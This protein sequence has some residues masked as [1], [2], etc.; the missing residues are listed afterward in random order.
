MHAD[1]SPNFLKILAM[2]PQLTGSELKYLSAMVG[3]YAGKSGAEADEL[4][5][6]VPDET[7]AERALQLLRTSETLSGPENALLASVVTQ[8]GTQ[9]GG[10]QEDAFDSRS[11][12]QELRR[13]NSTI[14]NITSVMDSLVEKNWVEN[15][16]EGRK[17]SHREY[18]LTQRGAAEALKICKRVSDRTPEQGR[19]AA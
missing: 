9:Y 4:Q 11:I 1:P 14:S 5:L 8:Y 19:G 16:D 17:G 13:V 12:T 3:A 2:L 7:R 18:R 15:L 10:G 6:V